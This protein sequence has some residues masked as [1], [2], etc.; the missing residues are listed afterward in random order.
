[1]KRTMEKEEQEKEIEKKKRQLADYV[2][3]A[4]VL[5]ISPEER[6]R[7]VNLM[8]DDLAKLL[9]QKK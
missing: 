3:I 5:G 1:M 2:R 9:K 8:L 6:E 7:Q 4:P